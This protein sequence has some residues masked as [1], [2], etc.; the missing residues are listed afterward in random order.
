LLPIVADP[1]KYRRHASLGFGVWLD[2]DWRRA[3]WNVD[4]PAKNY[5][6]PESFE[7]SVRAALT[8]ADEYVWIYTE[9]PRWWSAEGKPVKLPPAYDAAL[10]RAKGR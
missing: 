8:T 10:R 1:A 7:T 9:T 6:T 4:D 2:H 3:G 5:F